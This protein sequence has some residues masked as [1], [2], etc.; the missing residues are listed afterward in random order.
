MCHILHCYMPD[1]YSGQESVSQRM[2]RNNLMAIVPSNFGRGLNE[3]DLLRVLGKPLANCAA[4]NTLGYDQQRL[5]GQL[6]SKQ[7]HQVEVL[8]HN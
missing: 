3:E 5:C 8:K 1:I 4:L 6:R 2:W 7:D